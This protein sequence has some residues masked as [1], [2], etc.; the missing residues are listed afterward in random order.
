MAKQDIKDRNDV[1]RLVSTFYDTV[2]NDETLGPFFNNS[3]KD[4]DAHLEHLTTFWESSLFLKTKYSGDPL[5][6]HIDLD[7]RFNHSIS[8]MHFGIWLNLWLKTVNA[9]FEGDY[10]ENA[11]HRARKMGTFIFLKMFEARS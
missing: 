2:R 8:E 11:K 1:Y 10:A 9:L 4:W 6:A 7:K 5:Q 3:I